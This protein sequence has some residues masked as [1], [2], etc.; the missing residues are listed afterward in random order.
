MSSGMF[1]MGTTY[2]LWFVF[3]TQ[4]V[5]NDNFKTT[6]TKTFDKQNSTMTMAW[7]HYGWHQYLSKNSKSQNFRTPNFN[8]CVEQTE[9]QKKRPIRG[10]AR[11]S[12]PVVFLGN[13]G[14]SGCESVTQHHRIQNVLNNII[15]GPERNIQFLFSI[16]F[17]FFKFKTVIKC[18]LLNR[19]KIKI[20]IKIN[21]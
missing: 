3:K 10:L 19:N 17:L 18:F 2:H 11:Q 7:R 13:A 16:C 6:S 4:L 5:Q 8:G 20:I 14:F 15:S 21:I 9:S 12:P 1:H